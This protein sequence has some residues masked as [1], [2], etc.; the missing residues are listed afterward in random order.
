MVN[1]KGNMDDQIKYMEGKVGG[2]IREGVKM[3]CANRIGKWEIEAKKLIYET[4]AIH[5][6]Y[7]NIETWTNLRKTDIE[8]L[9]SIQGKVLR[10]LIG[11]PKS[12]PYWGVLYELD[13]MPIMVALT[14]KKLMFY[15]NLVNSEDNRI[16]KALVKEQEMSG[17]KECWVGNI[18]EEARSLDIKFSG[19]IVSGKPK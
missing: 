6:I 17:N 1:N 18:M 5:S 9:K 19:E 11:L 13:V 16:V 12:T 7:Y 2:I 10:G 3:C 14:Y 15:R 4:L 8:K